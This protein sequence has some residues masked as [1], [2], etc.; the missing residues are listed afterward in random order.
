MDDRHLLQAFQSAQLAPADF[1]HR[2]HLRVAWLHLA[3]AP[4]E[5]AY[6]TLKSGLF[7]LLEALGAPRSHYHETMTR[8]WLLAVQHFRH[9]VG[10]Q[11]DSE[12]FLEACPVLLN[13]EV[14][15]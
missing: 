1:R 13:R 11:A 6:E 5:E 9:R 3:A 15:L 10:P 8:A 7:R 12:R 4:F 14:M 2:E